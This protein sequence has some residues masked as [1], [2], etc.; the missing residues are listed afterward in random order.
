MTVISMENVCQWNYLCAWEILID[1][2]METLKSQLSISIL[3]PEYTHQ[4][5]PQVYA[6]ECE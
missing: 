4:N 3:L 5:K 2:S 1:P 6:E